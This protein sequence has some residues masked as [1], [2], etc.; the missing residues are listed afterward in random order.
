MPTTPLHWRCLSPS[1]MPTKVLLELTLSA[2][3]DTGFYEMI[4][5][6][7]PEGHVTILREDTQVVMTP[8]LVYATVPD[9]R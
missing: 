7:D 8:R 5:L 3:F 6:A 2:Q 9:R 4:Q 1:R